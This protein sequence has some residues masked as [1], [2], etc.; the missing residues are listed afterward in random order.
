MDETVVILKPDILWWSWWWYILKIFLNGFS[1]KGVKVIDMDSEFV[2]KWY[3]H[4]VDKPY[5]PEIEEFMTSKSV[6]VLLLS[7][8]HALDRMRGWLGPTD[9]SKAEIGQ[10]RY[11]RQDKM[12]NGFHAS[13]SAEA[14]KQEKKLIE[15]SFGQF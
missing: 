7:G 13:D 6:L 5:F 15:E 9:P 11:G 1:I 14:A 8:E 12:R 4:K 10:L 3:P 2:K